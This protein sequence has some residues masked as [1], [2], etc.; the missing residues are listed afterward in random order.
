MTGFIYLFRNKVNGKCY[1]GQTCNI[2]RRIRE[3]VY[4]AQSGSSFKFHQAIRKHG[5][6]NFEFKVLHKCAGE[7]QVILDEL[8]EKEIY[9]ID[10]Y[11]SFNNGYNMT[12]GSRGSR[13][14]HH[15]EEAK[16]RIGE[17]KK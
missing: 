17:A 12:E 8:N 14:L 3:H 2:Y 5:F 1:V 4:E 15:T 13:G 7:E 10:K 6:E 16:K 11:D 9:Y